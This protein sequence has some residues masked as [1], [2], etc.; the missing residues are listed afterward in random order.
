MNGVGSYTLDMREVDGELVA[1]ARV[2]VD[3]RSAASAEAGDLVLAAREGRT[4][5]EDWI[6][7][8]ELVEDPALGRRDDSEITFFK[9]VGVAVQD[10][11]AARLAH[12]RARELGL[13]VELEL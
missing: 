7:L 6:E 5:V 9:S 3:S 11:A 1:G 10:L 4:R 13:G 8:G 2:F 12:D